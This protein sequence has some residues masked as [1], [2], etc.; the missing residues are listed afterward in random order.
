[1]LDFPSGSL[2]KNPPAMR[3]TWV[4]SLGWADTLEKGTATHS[5]IP[6]EFH[7]LYIVRG[8]TKSW[9]WLS[10]FHFLSLHMM[11]VLKNLLP[12]QH[13]HYGDRSIIML[14]YPLCPPGFLSHI[15][16]CKKFVSLRLHLSSLRTGSMGSLSWG[17]QFNI[18]VRRE[19]WRVRCLRLP[20]WLSGKESTCNGR[21]ESSIPGLGRSPAVGNG[22]SFQYSCLENSMD[23]GAWRVIVHE[24]ARVRHNLATKPPPPPRL[25]RLVC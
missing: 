19:F 7:E 25:L 14:V 6:G 5:N 10:D 20:G 12:P 17:R 18:I 15:A 9:T 4:W 3:E 13:R 22:I 24:I 8:I 11:I 1:M 23:R 2:I 21:G 16:N